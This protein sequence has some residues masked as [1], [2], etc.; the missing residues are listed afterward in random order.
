MEENMPRTEKLL[1]SREE[2]FYEW[3]VLIDGLKLKLTNNESSCVLISAPFGWGK[4]SFTNIVA[5]ELK[6]ENIKNELKWLSYSIEAWKYELLDSA[7]VV[8]QLIFELINKQL[9][10]LYEDVSLTEKTAKKLSNAFDANKEVFVGVFKSATKTI[11]KNKLGLE[12]DIKDFKKVYSDKFIKELRELSKKLDMSYI[13][14]IEFFKKFMEAIFTTGTAKQNIRILFI[15]KDCDR[16]SPENLIRI[17]DC[18]HHLDV[19]DRIKFLVEADIETINSI[20][21]QKYNI[22]KYTE[23]NK[24]PEQPTN[25]HGKLVLSGYIDKIFDHT[26]VLERQN[27]KKEKICDFL[28]HTLSINAFSPPSITIDR[29]TSNLSISHRY[30]KNKLSDD[31][32]KRAKLVGVDLK[33]LNVFVLNTLMILFIVNERSHQKINSMF[34]PTFVNVPR[35]NELKYEIT[36]G[37][38]FYTGISKLN[39][40]PHYSDE[41]INYL[42]SLNIK[43]DDRTHSLFNYR[44][45]DFSGFTFNQGIQKVNENITAINTTWKKLI[46]TS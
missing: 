29:L 33:T 37:S 2:S 10:A 39:Y 3:G 43:I 36:S 18:I 32:V 40:A 8:E 20:L 46:Q 31:F 17:I 38:F 45:E 9:L 19:D 30:I 22:G 42:N 14:T 4:S 5:Q 23:I 1:N 34:V 27:L 25:K 44:H 24:E 12:L 21:C 26:V 11:L 6:E 15:L 35:S 28:N 7:T 13:S 41:F 16:C